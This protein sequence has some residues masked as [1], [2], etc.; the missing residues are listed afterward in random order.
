VHVEVDYQARLYFNDLITVRLGVVKVGA[1]S[2]T[3]AFAIDREDGER[4]VSGR[5]IIVHASS[6]T[7]GS[8]PWPDALRLAL[9][10]PRDFAMAVSDWTAVDR[11]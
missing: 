9:A 4:A 8:A 2:C 7:E 5:M 3:Y 10:A 6:T 1:S 11:P